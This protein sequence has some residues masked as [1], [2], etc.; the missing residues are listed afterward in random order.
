MDCVAAP[1]VVPN[2]TPSRRRQ[3]GRRQSGRRQW[4]R[5]IVLAAV[6]VLIVAYGVVT[7]VVFVHPVLGSVADPQAVFVLGGYGHRA[8]RAV[9]VARDRHVRTVEL[10]IGNTEADC[11]RAAGVTIRC[12]APDPASTQGEARSVERITRQHHWTRIL[13]VAGTTQV[14]RARLRI[15][16][17]YTGQVAF[18]DVDPTGF[19]QWVRD[20]VYDE[21]AMVKALLWQWGC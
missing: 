21:A 4:W 8:D 10:S 13:V 14:S 20:T 3:S 6:A 1:E 18:A 9:E 5:T 15:G 7:A 16:R 17:C 2:P 19:V 12:Y 11:P